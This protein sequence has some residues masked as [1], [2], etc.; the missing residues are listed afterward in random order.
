MLSL[1]WL[2]LPVAAAS[3]WY[4]A[5]RTQ[6][7]QNPPKHSLSPQYFQG[8]NYL[9][10]EKPDKAIKVFCQLVEANDPQALELHLALGNLFRRRGEVDRAIHIHLNLVNHDSISSEF[11][12]VATVELAH[13]YLRAGLLDRAEGLLLDLLERNAG[14]AA[15]HALLQIIYQQEKEWDKAVDIALRNT[16]IT[17]KQY[18]VIAHY[19][20]ELAEEQ[21]NQRNPQ[22]AFALLEQALEYDNSC[23]R[24]NIIKGR[25]YNQCDDYNKALGAYQS[26]AK[27]NAIY[28][29]EVVREMLECS[30][31]VGNT[32]ELMQFLRSNIKKQADLRCVEAFV[33]LLRERKSDHQAAMFLI[34]TLKSSPS[35]PLLHQLFQLNAKQVQGEMKD[36]LRIANETLTDLLKHRSSY[37]CED[38]GFSG[39]TLHWLCPGCKAWGSTVPASNANL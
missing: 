9:I 2:L 31:Q 33:D 4:V 24:A 39:R 27:Q 14:D 13:D 37:I 30:Y 25:I 18:K 15:V 5:K 22:R 8:L 32:S 11:K 28:L 17:E 34:N 10:D 6:S 36:T 19:Y 1:L 21:S 3:G 29:G 12:Y 20:C 23:V 35:L 7:Q 16:K 38:C 26:I